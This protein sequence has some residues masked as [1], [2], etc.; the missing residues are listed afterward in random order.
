M[1][2][3]VSNNLWGHGSHWLTKCEDAWRM[4]KFEFAIDR[5]PEFQAEVGKSARE[6]H[7]QTKAE[8]VLNPQKYSSLM[9][10]F[11]VTAYVFRFIT[12]C[13][14]VPEE[15]KT[16]PLEVREINRAEKFRLKALQ[17]EEFPEDLESHK[18]EK[19][20]QEPSHAKKE[21]C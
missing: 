6:L 16:T 7:T 12:N 10:L 2:D 9:K 20:R 4:V 21:T 14:A 5:N 3:L 13:K 1:K 17:N 19:K 18:Q 15:R 8:P 11:N